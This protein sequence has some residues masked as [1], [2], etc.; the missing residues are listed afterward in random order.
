MKCRVLKGFFDGKDNNKPYEANGEFECTED[1]F[2]EIQRKG[3]YLYAE[4]EKVAE[5]GDMKPEKATKK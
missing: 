3:N 5:T 1:R 4:P 2:K